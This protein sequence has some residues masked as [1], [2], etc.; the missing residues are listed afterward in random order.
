VRS[1]GECHATGA[2]AFTE[3]PALE[4]SL[5][6]RMLRSVAFSEMPRAPQALPVDR[7]RAIVRGLIAALYPDEPSRIAA[8]RIFEDATR[9][10][11]PVSE[12]ARLAAVH[13]HAG[14]P[15]AAQFALDRAYYGVSR[16]TSAASGSMT[17]AIAIDLAAAAIADCARPGVADRD[18][19]M[20]RAL[21]LEALMTDDAE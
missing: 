15:E 18:A 19:C 12:P 6:T 17:A 14:V 10:R 5:V 8:R 13:A 9:W 16:G 21:H 2:R 1:C 3:R 11:A 7:R 4:R 20:D